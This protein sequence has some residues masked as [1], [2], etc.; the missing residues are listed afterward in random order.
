MEKKDRARPPPTPPVPKRRTEEGDGF[1]AGRGS[2]EL[3]ERAFR[4]SSSI[5]RRSSA[6]RAAN[7][8]LRTKKG[9][10][11]A[12]PLEKKRR[13]SPFYSLFYPPPSEAVA[14]SFLRLLRPAAAAWGLS[15]G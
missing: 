3:D 4:E 12:W 5:V 8:V 10:K 9:K 1:L 11:L 13:S 7:P 14:T 15:L 6:F 2:L